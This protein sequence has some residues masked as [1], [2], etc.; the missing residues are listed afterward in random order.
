MV[1][2][3]IIRSRPRRRASPRIAGG[4]IPRRHEAHTGWRSSAA[5]VQ[6]AAGVQRPWWSLKK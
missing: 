2:E 3:E 4:V 1:F 5:P 6:G